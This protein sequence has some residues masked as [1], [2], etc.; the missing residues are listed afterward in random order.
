MPVE[1]ALARRFHAARQVFEEAIERPPSER[2]EYLALACASDPDLRREV[3]SL[4]AEHSDLESNGPSLGFSL[5]AADLSPGA[6]LGSFTIRRWLASGGMGTVYEA[7][8]DQPRRLVALK[9]LASGIPSTAAIQR[10][11]REAELLGRLRHPG[12]AQ[13]YGA[14]IQP[15]P[16]GPAPWI[17]LELIPSARPLT[18]F[19][20]E[21]GLSIRRRVELFVEV[22]D[23]VQHA[24]QLGV[25]HRDLKPSNLL[26]GADGRPRVIDFG[27]GR[28][29]ERSA[30]GAQVTETGQLLGTLRYMSPEQCEGRPELADTRSDVYSLGVVLFELLCG[31]LPYEVSAERLA[32]SLQVIRSSPPRRPS[33]LAPGVRGDLETILL[34][35]L[36]KDRDLR[37]RSAAELADDLRAWMGSRPIAAQRAS[38]WV[39]LRRFARREPAKA[40]LAIALGVGVPALAALAGFSLAHAEEARVGREAARRDRVAR[41]LERGFLEMSRVRLPEARAALDEVLREEPGSVE[42]LAALAMVHVARR[43]PQA[44]LAELERRPELV[45]RHASL[46]RLR[47]DARA[48]LS[49]EPIAS[50]PAQEALREPVD[51][52]VE[53]LRLLRGGGPRTPETFREAARLF[54]RAGSAAPVPQPLHWFLLAEAA[55][56]ANDP[57]LAELVADTLRARWP[58]SAQAWHWIG[59]T[60]LD[61]DARRAAEACDRALALDPSMADTATNLGS[62][63]RA[64][65]DVMGAIE[66]HKRAA[67]A[68]PKH[69]KAHFNLGNALVDA[70]DLAGAA[71]AYREAV[72]LEPRFAH[73]WE[74]LA[75]VLDMQ[76]DLEAAADAYLRALELAPRSATIH[77]NYAGTL[78]KLGRLSEAARE[79]RSAFEAGFRPAGIDQELARLE[80]VAAAPE[81]LPAASGR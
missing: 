8:Q 7:E 33:S 73:S 75:N 46:Q 15:T 19:A 50:R 51:W 42:A 23:A 11:E 49:G 32:E 80:K 13:V 65:G 20:R 1:E 70:N 16:L 56:N 22:C 57:E 45:E 44:A 26:V 74:N 78:E 3:S 25:L 9:V 72:A 79:L 12:I 43:D 41:L 58:E 4:L 27:I 47:S 34:K 5:G 54:L 76:G 55:G 10:F 61:F 21:E 66:A 69:W 29:V 67:A 68:D 40:A 52:L 28:T 17:A 48:I 30:A 38:R 39:R 35:T 53:G 36:E 6:R 71:A 62:A 18:T 59:F 63:R 64:L 77:A 24:H 31:A 37:Y 81:S 2:G 14:G 60:L